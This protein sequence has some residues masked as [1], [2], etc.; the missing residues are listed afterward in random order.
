MAQ[1]GE[2]GGPKLREVNRTSLLEDNPELAKEWHPTKNGNLTPANVSAGSGL[3]VWW[4]CPEGEDHEWQATVGNRNGLRRGCPVCSGTLAVNSNCLA[5]LHPDV[6]A[7]WHPIKNGALTPHDVTPGSSKRVWWKC[8]KGSDHEWLASVAIRSN[9]SGCG[10]CADRVVVGSNC[11]ATT[12]PELAKEWHPTKNGTLLPTDVVAG[13]G[14]KVWW[15]CNVEADHVW[16]AQ[17]VARKE[18]SACPCCAGRKVVMSNCLLTTHPELAAEWHPTKNGRLKPT[19]VVAGARKKV[20]WKC[21]EGEDH[22][23]RQDLVTRK[24]GNGCPICSGHKVVK[25]NCLSTTHPSLASE[26]HPTKNK[27]LTP[28]HVHAGSYKEFGG[29]VRGKIM[30][31]R[32]RCFIVVG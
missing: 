1:Q 10:V 24:S 28:E 23:W 9:G 19:D 21:P 14:K 2:R 29:N 20:W 3:K 7:E 30:S 17:L 25:S 15:Q 5:T 6:A 32:L 31:G 26:W 16:K 27:A 4:K 12:H 22:E 11:L 18:G 13:S 8:A